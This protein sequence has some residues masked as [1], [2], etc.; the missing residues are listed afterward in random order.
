MKAVFVFSYD[1][2]VDDE[3]WHSTKCGRYHLW[4]SCV[5][6]RKTLPS[7]AL[8]C[9]EVSLIWNFRCFVPWFADLLLLAVSDFLSTTM[10]WE[11]SIWLLEG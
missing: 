6:K 1:F 5:L 3:Q 8:F 9:S 10:Y 2:G 4:M 7:V 11:H